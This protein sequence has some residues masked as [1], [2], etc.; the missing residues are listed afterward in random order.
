MLVEGVKGKRLILLTGDYELQVIWVA[1]AAGH[2]GVS[3]GQIAVV[4]VGVYFLH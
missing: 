3:G 4:K 1:D 2:E